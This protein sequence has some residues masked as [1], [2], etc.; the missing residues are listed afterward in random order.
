[1][2]KNFKPRTQVQGQPVDQ[3]K[4]INRFFNLAKNIASTS[5]Y[6]KIRHAELGCILGM[7]RNVTTGADVYVCRINKNGVFRNSK[8]CS[9]C[10]SALKYVGVKRVYYT[11]NNNTVEMY[12]L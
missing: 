10:H 8:P 4:K 7:P 6:G 2:I 5:E 11:T 1:M 3:S 9:M 12:K